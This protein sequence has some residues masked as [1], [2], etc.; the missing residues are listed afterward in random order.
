[1]KKIPIISVFAFLFFFSCGTATSTLDGIEA[2]MNNNKCKMAREA[3]I[4][5]LC[6][7]EYRQDTT[8]T[9]IPQSVFD[10]SI[11]TCPVTGEFYIMI[12]DGDSRE[13][14]CPSGHGESPF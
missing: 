2:R 7:L 3:F 12:V 13:I 1:M 6:N 14:S 10:D 4:T 11:N 8:F 5:A 9:E